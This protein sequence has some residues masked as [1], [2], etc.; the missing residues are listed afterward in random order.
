MRSFTVIFQMQVSFHIYHACL[1]V[2]HVVKIGNT[3]ARPR[4]IDADYSG[5]KLLFLV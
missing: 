2:A 1:S 3:T 4:F 5:E